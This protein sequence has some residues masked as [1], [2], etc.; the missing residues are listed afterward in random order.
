MPEVEIKN[1][2]NKKTGSMPLDDRVF[3]GKVSKPLLHEAVQLHLASRRQGTAATKTKGL[4]RGG[5]RKPW[6]QK[7]TGRARAGSNR[8]PLWRGGGTVFGPRPRSYA[9][10]MPKK[11][12][13]AALYS[14][15]ASK[16]QEEGLVVLEEFIFTEAKTRTM[17]LL[18][19]KLDLSGRILVLTSQ[20]QDDL[21]RMIGNLPN[22]HLLEVRQLN[23][24]DLIL[25]DTLLTTQRDISRLVEV[26]GTHES[27]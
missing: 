14:A 4:I 2:H 7:G 23:V 27:A 1:H 13:R 22:V 25:A 26:W 20:K 21:N 8:S 16:V 11:K 18:L 6:K 19:K 15:L 17:A 12:A 10:S 24:Y 3:G 9:Y 5:G